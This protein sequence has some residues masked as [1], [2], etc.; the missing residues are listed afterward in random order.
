M[1]RRR[2]RQVEESEQLEQIQQTVDAE[3]GY[4]FKTWLLSSAKLF[5]FLCLVGSLVGFLLIGFNFMNN[6]ATPDP[7]LINDPTVLMGQRASGQLA[8]SV[9]RNITI[10]PHGYNSKEN[11]RIANYLLNELSLIN[12]EYESGNCKNGNPMVIYAR[13]PVNMI[14][15]YSDF[16]AYY[17]SSN[18]IVKISPVGSL[19][20]DSLL[21]SA[22]Y[23]SASV[24]FG[25]TD[26]GIA[27]S[28]M[29]SSIS[30]LSKRL[31]NN[32]IDSNV[33]FNFNNGEEIGLFG[34]YSFVLHPLF[35]TVKAF[36][37][38]GYFF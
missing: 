3:R 21:I 32:T 27:I 6:N 17:E 31:C 26:D 35:E 10:K 16:N 37:N 19:S 25:A 23:D 29:I 13:D 7:I 9:L 14:F 15:N 5:E 22:H 34:A 36:I 1:L 20:I 11:L 18:I 28:S 4:D 30:A 24:S 8:Y 12:S 2:T 38:L 33:I